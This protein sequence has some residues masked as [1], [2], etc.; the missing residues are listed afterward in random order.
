LIGLQEGAS[1]VGAMWELRVGKTV[2][3]ADKNVVPSSLMTIFRESDRY[4]DEELCGGTDVFTDQEHDDAEVQRS[5]GYRAP[6]VTVT[7]RLALLG[8]GVGVVRREVVEYL[9][10]AVADPAPSLGTRVR[11]CVDAAGVDGRLG[12]VDRRPLVRA[13]GRRQ[14]GVLLVV[15]EQRY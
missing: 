11:G 10:E 9:S 1:R 14:A 2:A 3:F 6:L 15:L 7:A 13:D 8:F 12:V 5:I 4:Y